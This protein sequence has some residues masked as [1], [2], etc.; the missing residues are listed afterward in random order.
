[1]TMN[2]AAHIAAWEWATIGAMGVIITGFAS[3][4]WAMLNNKI[5]GHAES[6]ERA[7]A[8]AE[9]RRSEDV[10]DLEQRHVTAVATLEQ[11]HV[12]AIAALQTQHKIEYDELRNKSHTQANF[13]QKHGEEIAVLKEHRDSAKEDMKELRDEM[14]SGFTRTNATL[15]E[16]GRSL[17]RLL[18][19]MG[20]STG[21]MPKVT[22]GG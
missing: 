14:R 4:I 8:A 2:D 10:A 19:R 7:L 21:S 20:G 3:I 13:I 9:K 16:M 11:R 6:H 1:M 22:P 17:N 12:T 5:N 15:E 18:G